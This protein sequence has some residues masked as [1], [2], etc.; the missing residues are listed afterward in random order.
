MKKIF[1]LL[2][3]YFGVYSL[4]Q[5]IISDSA[6]VDTIKKP[7]HWSVVAK[8]SVMF[9][10]A[11]FS[12]WVGGGANNV[13][14]LASANYNLVYENGRHLWENIIILNYGQNTTKGVGTRKTQDV[15]NVSTN[16]GRQF[17]K[18]WY[19]S[20]GASVLSQFSGGFEDGNNPE[21][22]KISN[23]MAPGYVNAGLGITYRPDENLT[24]TLR[25]ANGRFT[26]VLDKEL[27]LA[28]NYGLKTDGDFF[29]MQIGFL[30]SAIYKVK[31]MENI[32]M[33]NTGS[34]FSNYLENP[35]HM[36]LSYNMLL[37][38]KINRFV[39]SIV[40]LDLMYDHNQ[41]QKTQLK[42]TLGIGF[43][44]NIDNGVKRSDRKDSQW[45]LK[46]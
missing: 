6:A 16:Y 26:F 39:S 28:G 23:F 30:G 43:A 45:W 34:I 1:V 29:L 5:V 44:Y 4:A 27:Q 3:M 15:L 25:P 10:Q 9:N 11:A 38:M 35:D 40:T 31:L 41:I 7:R 20:T 32:E 13:G 24:V 8:N 22:K 36:V 37:N 42:Q 2:F 19:V 18:S 17:S 21:A 46:K 33:T 12:N 14:W